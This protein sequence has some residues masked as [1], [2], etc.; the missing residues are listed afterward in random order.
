MDHPSKEWKDQ[1][2]WNLSKDKKRFLSRDIRFDGLGDADDHR[3]CFE[4]EYIR[5]RLFKGHSFEMESVKEMYPFYL[6]SF[7]S[8]AYKSHSS[9]VRKSW[10]GILGTN[11][12][13]WEDDLLVPYLGTNEEVDLGF[14]KGKLLGYKA[15]V[16]LYLN[17]NWSKEKF[18]NL[19]E[20]QTESIYSLLAVEKEALERKGY[21]FPKKEKSRPKSYWKKKLK[22]L[23]HY[24]LLECVDLKERFAIETFGKDAYT[25]EKVYR[26]EIRKL[27]P[28]LPCSWIDV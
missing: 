18:L 15:G 21:I 25:E 6:G 27:L 11:T 22:A 23:G 26:R 9:K 24:R 17:P 4:W 12:K 20:K 14:Y 8:K 3:K 13:N 2:T 10:A 5:T 19:V 1:Q 16:T 7:P 28:D